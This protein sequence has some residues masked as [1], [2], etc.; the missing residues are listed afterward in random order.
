MKKLR[1]PQIDLSLP[2][3]ARIATVGLAEASE[4]SEI[5]SI[6]EKKGFF[7]KNM[8]MNTTDHER[9]SEHSLSKKKS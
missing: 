7:H 6:I 2:E 1:Q 5:H 8:N 9:V 4:A 3:G